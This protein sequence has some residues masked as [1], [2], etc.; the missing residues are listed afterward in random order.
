M[1]TPLIA[2][3]E[4]LQRLLSDGPVPPDDH[5]HHFFLRPRKLHQEAQEEFSAFIDGHFENLVGGRNNAAADS[6]R[7][8]LQWIFLGLAQAAMNG[9]WLLITA[10][11]IPTFWT[12][13]QLPGT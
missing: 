10:V 9:R 6:L 12:L 3:L 4:E 5:K 11:W 8:H 1:T 2:E 13:A 7:R